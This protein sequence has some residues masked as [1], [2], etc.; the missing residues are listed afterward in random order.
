MVYRHFPPLCNPITVHRILQA[1]ILE[2]VDFPFSRGSSQPR[3]QTQ[4][5]CIAGGFLPAE[6][7]GKPKNIGVGSL[8]LLQQIFLSQESNQGL[9]HCRWILY[10]RSYEG[11]PH[12]TEAR[13]QRYVNREISDVQT[14]LR[15]GRGTRDHIADIRW[16]VEKAREFQKNICFCFIDYTKA[17]DCVD[18]NKLWKTLQEMGRTDHLT[19]LLRNMYA[20][21]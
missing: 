15:K 14:G 13:L 16:I 1:T 6:P 21:Q 18:H 8:S 2:W 10:Q 20:G 19:C 9:L 12:M 11:S 7:Q 4:V 5:S 3:D 17:F